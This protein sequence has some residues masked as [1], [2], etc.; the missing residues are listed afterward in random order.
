[1]ILATPSF[2]WITILDIIADERVSE[3]VYGC[4]RCSNNGFGAGVIDLAPSVTFFLALFHFELHRKQKRDRR[5]THTL[6]HTHHTHTHTYTHRERER[7]RERGK[8]L[9]QERERAY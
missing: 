9:I 6:T 2:P 7:E 4:Y 1:V 5:E 8:S 3:T